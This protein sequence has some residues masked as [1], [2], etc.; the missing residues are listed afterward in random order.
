MLY[1]HMDYEFMDYVKEPELDT[2]T[3]TMSFYILT[4]KPAITTNYFCVI[5]PN[6]KEKITHPDCW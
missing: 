4:V 1:A 3:A 5:V 2:A 6:F